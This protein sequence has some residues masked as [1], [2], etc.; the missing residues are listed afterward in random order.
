MAVDVSLPSGVTVGE[1][2][3]AIVDMVEGPAAPDATPMLWR[4]DTLASGVV[5]EA[6]SL[7]DNDIRDGDLLVL[8]QAHVPGL[9]P[10]RT[11]PVRA[12]VRAHPPAGRLGE[13]VRGAFCVAA[14]GLASL[15]LGSGAGTAYA[16][17]NLV[18]TATG[19]CAAAVVAMTSGF[20][21]ASNVAFISLAATTGFLAV[22]SAPAA[23]NVLLAAAAGMSADLLVLRWSGRTSPVMVAALAFS[24]LC[25]LVTL[26]TLP[27]VSTGAA[28]ASV[29]LVLLALAPRAAVLTSRLRLEDD[30]LPEDEVAARAD[31]AHATLTGL[32]VGAAGGTTA[33]SVLLTADTPAGAGPTL[34][35]TALLTVILLLRIRAHVDPGRRIALLAA[36]FGCG[37][38]CLRVALGAYPQ[39][40]GAAGA[41]LVAI[42]LISVLA[43]Q[44]GSA[45]SR[46]CNR[47][48]YV[49][50]AAV[51][52]A[53][54]WVGGIY[55]LLD[56]FHL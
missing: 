20:G 50:L 6:L 44:R 24:L 14:T 28:L 52:P 31:A 40:V 36:G 15:A 41:V 48:E 38:T 2:L 42:G 46:T 21:W 43:R 9:G 22:P 11:Q 12:V 54:G 33:G 55:D 23:P 26:T 13:T 47:V 10:V 8:S 1:L 37:G 32:V 39:Y 4:L 56:G 35:F 5:D 25:A 27:L 19:T 3:P 30:P 16:T 51:V 34:A 17:T 45:W 49:A 53:A 29:A 18:V 7:H